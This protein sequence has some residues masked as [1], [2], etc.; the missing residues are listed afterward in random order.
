MSQQRRVVAAVAAFAL[1]LTACGS[2]LTDEQ[3]EFALAGGGGGT[4]VGDQLAAGEGLGE[5]DLL[6]E[7]DLDLP[8]A[9]GAEVGPEGGDTAPDAAAGGAGSGGGDGSGDGDGSGGGDGSGDGDGS[10][11]GDGAANSNDTRAAPP[12]GNGGAT[13]TGVTEDRIVLANVSDISGAVP[14]LFEDAQ[15]A[16]AAYVAYFTASEGTIYGRQLQLLPLDSRLDAGQARAQ[17]LRACEEAFAGVGSMSAFEEGAAGPV[18]DCGIPD[19]RATTTSAEMQ[20]LPNVYSG[21][22]QT[23]GNVNGSAF[24]YWA[25]QHPE[26]VKKAA[27]LWI[28]NSTT[29]F[30]TGQNRKALAKVGYNW[31]YEQPIQIAE[32]NYAAFVIEMKNRGVEF[33]T[34]QGDYTQAIRLRQ[35][36]QQQNFE[37]VVYGLQPNIYSPRFLEAGGSS[38]EGT[39]IYMSAVPLEEIGNNE[40]MQLYAQWLKQVDPRAHPTY[41]GLYAWSVSKLT[42]ETLKKIGPE[43]TRAKLIAELDK[44]TGWTGNGLHAPQDIGPRRN[45]DCHLVVQVQDGR[46]V[47]TWPAKD[48]VCR[49]RALRVD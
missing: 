14:G 18:K 24:R 11:G 1:L 44:V 38:V 8:E 5:A 12:G 7:T 28:E 10:G 3:R 22:V 49:D 42:V 32:T 48:W 20:R 41:L 40:E 13:D 34:F 4:G 19:V 36:M 33:V 2:R 30:Q 47:R 37:P 25:E 23:V 29:N 9:G 26:A 35:A 45:N 17:Y 46:F 39:E 31:V 6:D 27:Y 15:K 43:V 21:E 16:A